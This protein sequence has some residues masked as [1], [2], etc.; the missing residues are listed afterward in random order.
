L[1]FLVSLAVIQRSGG[2]VIKFAGDALLAMWIPSDGQLTSD[3]V[4]KAIQAVDKLRQSAARHGTIQKKEGLILSM[5][6][7][8]GSVSLHF[9]QSGQ[10]RQFI[11]TGQGIE[12]VS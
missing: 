10:Q 9:L 3:F 5:G 8:V 12:E 6:V 11:S 4:L 7:S 1:T 2:D